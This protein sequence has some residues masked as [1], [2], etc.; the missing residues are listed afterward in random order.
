[1]K[2][3]K[4]AVP[5]ACCLETSNKVAAAQGGRGYRLNIVDGTN[6]N[7]RLSQIFITLLLIRQPEPAAAAGI[8]W[9]HKSSVRLTR[10]W[11]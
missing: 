11:L 6:P 4:T 8:T 9:G 10:R 1:M 5:C 7:D 3:D 2:A